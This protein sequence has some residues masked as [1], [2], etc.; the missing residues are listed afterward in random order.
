[1]LI[2]DELHT[3]FYLPPID[4][5]KS[6]DGLSMM[7]T[8]TLQKELNAG[9]LFLF[10][11]FPRSFVKILYILSTKQAPGSLLFIFVVISLPILKDLSV[12]R[13]LSDI[14]RDL[15]NRILN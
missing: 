3:F 10:P 2:P 1:M 14:P 7:V 4:F 8:Q 6:I 11:T 5:R 15:Q 9:H 13:H 12:P